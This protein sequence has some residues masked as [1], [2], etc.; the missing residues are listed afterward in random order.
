MNDRC[1]ALVKA[2]N[3]ACGTDNYEALSHTCSTGMRREYEIFLEHTRHKLRSL[4][5]GTKKWWKLTDT[6]MRKSTK[7]SS[8]FSD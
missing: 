6:L 1:L 2:K 7:M 3:D 4:P 8:F 5:R